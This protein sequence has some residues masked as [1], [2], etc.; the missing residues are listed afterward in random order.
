MT[1]LANLDVTPPATFSTLQSRSDVVNAVIVALLTVFIISNIVSVVTK[2]VYDS[3]ELSFSYATLLRAF[4]FINSDDPL[5]LISWLRHNYTYKDR[6]AARYRNALKLARLLWPLFARLIILV[7]SIASVAI[8]VPGTKQLP[9][10]APDHRLVIDASAPAPAAPLNRLCADLPLRTRLGQLRSSASYCSCATSFSFKP[11]ELE[12]VGSLVE[13]RGLIFTQY[14]DGERFSVIFSR[15]LGAA[16]Q[17]YVAWKRDATDQAPLFSDL[18]NLDSDALIDVI[19]AALSQSTRQDCSVASRSENEDDPSARLA[20]VNCEFDTGALIPVVESYVTNALK[21][22]PLPSGTVDVRLDK[23]AA[24]PATGECPVTVLVSRPIVNILPLGLTLILLVVVNILVSVYTSRRGNAFDAG[25]HLIKEALG[26]DTT[27][28]PLEENTDRQE[29][30][31]LPLRKWRCGRGAAH[32]GFIGREGD[33][34]VAGFDAATNVCGCNRV[35]TE[36]ERA[37]AAPELPASAV[38]PPGSPVP[39]AAHVHSSVGSS[40][41]TPFSVAAPTAGA[42]QTLSGAGLGGG[43]AT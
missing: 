39:S 3:Q 23:A 27:S 18:A 5:R 40:G 9:A 19:S 43:N 13:G 15:G 11:E 6:A 8:A 33:V 41:A 17:F 16:H 35:A 28:N 37:A 31:E 22:V 1:V 36:I 29:V 38:L 14:V 24:S 26:H 42:S 4:I 34:P 20:L 32:M 10:C 30:M 12:S 7:V 21:W 25:F 2:L